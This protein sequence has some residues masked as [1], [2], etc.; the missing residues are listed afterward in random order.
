VAAS[1]AGGDHVCRDAWGPAHVERHPRRSNVLACCLRHTPAT[2]HHAAVFARAWRK[3]HIFN[4]LCLQ[5]N[6]PHP[7]HSPLLLPIT[8]SETRFVCSCQSKHGA[9]SPTERRHGPCVSDGPC[10]ALQTPTDFPAPDP[11]SIF[12][13]PTPNSLVHPQAISLLL[14]SPRND[15]IKLQTTSQDPTP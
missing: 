13:P 12:N 11:A 1:V 9:F 3:A 15:L 4:R 5:K 7:F 2:W 8:P 10:P 6:G 14:Q